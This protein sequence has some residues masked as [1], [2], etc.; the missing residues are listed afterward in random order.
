MPSSPHV[1]S[2]Q[3]GRPRQFDSTEDADVGTGKPWESAIIK[4]PVSGPVSVFTENIDGDHQADLVHHGGPDKAVCA[5]ASE[6]FGFWSQT[7][8]EIDWR[9]GCFGENLTLSG[10]VEPDVCIGDTFKVGDCVLQ[11]SQPRQP[12]WKLSR[13]WYLPKLAVLVQQTRFTGWYFRVL[14]SGIIEAGNV[15]RLTDRQYPQWSITAANDVMFA[16][17]RDP[18]RDRALADCPALSQSWRESLTQRAS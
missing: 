13:R 2:I 14:Q 5:Y 11:I 15:M 8:P 9:P 7:Y 6:R 16:K 18:A 17:P 10:L 3:V 4:R 1:V 12:C